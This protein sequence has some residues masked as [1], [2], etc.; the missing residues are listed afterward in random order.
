MASQLVLKEATAGNP[1]AAQQRLNLLATVEL[2]SVSEVAL[3][4]AQVLVNRGPVPAKAAA[5]AL[6]IAIAVTNGVEYLLTW[7]CKHIANANMRSQIER[8][9]RTQGYEPTI[10]CTPDEL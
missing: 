1:T 5:D 6:H 4:L 9:C 2:L 3:T 8:L 10:I 7:N